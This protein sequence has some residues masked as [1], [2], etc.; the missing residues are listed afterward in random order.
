MKLVY[1]DTNMFISM[2]RLI[3]W[4]C[5]HLLWLPSL[6][7]MN[8]SGM[9][10]RPSTINVPDLVWSFYSFYVFTLTSMVGGRI[11]TI[12]MMTI[13]DNGG[14][15]CSLHS[16][17]SCL[18]SPFSIWSIR[19]TLVTCLGRSYSSWG[20]AC[21]TKIWIFKASFEFLSLLRY[22]NFNVCTCVSQI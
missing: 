7:S 11:L 21:L 17:N 4:L 5:G 13:F 3:H 18:R 15:S 6:V 9:S 10:S 22:K 2:L 14:I 20:I 8:P 12:T 1:P 19:I 16:Q